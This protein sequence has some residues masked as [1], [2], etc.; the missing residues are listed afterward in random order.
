MIIPG[1]VSVTFRPK[2]PL[3]ICQ[4]CER[5]GLRAIE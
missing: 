1:L 3:E 5:A 4:L 2:T